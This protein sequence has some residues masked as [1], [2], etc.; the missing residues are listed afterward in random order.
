MNF[1]FEDVEEAFFA[2]LLTGFGSL[3]DCSRIR[4]ESAEFGSHVG[5]LTDRRRLEVKFG[6][7]DR[8]EEGNDSERP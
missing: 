4:A 2:D 7:S 3:E 5:V 6:E 1:R 8:A